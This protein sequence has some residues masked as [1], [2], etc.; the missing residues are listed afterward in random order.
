MQ[1]IFISV[2]P[3]RDTVAQVRTYVQGKC[4]TSFI[5][6]FT[7]FHPRLIGLTGKIVFRIPRFVF[8]LFILFCVGICTYFIQ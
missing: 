1:P 4:R 2:D 3:M 8:L 7:E 6:L 5:L